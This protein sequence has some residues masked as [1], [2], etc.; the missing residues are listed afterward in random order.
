MPRTVNGLWDTFIGFEN[1][2]KGYLAAAKGKRYRNEVLAFKLNLEENL[3]AIIKDLQENTYKPLPLRQF[4]ITDPKK[5]LISAPAFRDRVVHHAL[6]RIIEPIFE[7]RFIN[8]SFA[9]RVGRGT[10][11]AMQHVHKSTQ[12][13]KRRWGNYYVFKGDVT[14]Y[15]P[16]INHDILKQDVR[17]AIRDRKILYLIDTIIDSHN[18]DGRERT[19][20][21]IGTLT[22]QLFANIYLDPLDHFLK[23]TCQ[24]KYY[25]RYM[26]DFLIIHGD[27]NFLRELYGWI[28]RLLTELKVSLNPKTEIYHGK[29][30]I[31]FCGYRIWPSHIKPRKRTVKRAKRRMRKMTM[32]YQ[33]DPAVL[34]HAKA[35]LQSFLGYIMHCSGYRTTKSLLFQTAFLPKKG[36]ALTKVKSRV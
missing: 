31:D 7:K 11:A 4:F 17:R 28:E 2:Y 33:K 21:P 26:D 8:E 5:R 1:I 3:F 34:E 22:S 18:T 25:A 13:A 6:V 19:G 12:L 14:K 36:N 15:F 23:E 27:K 16:S 24:I 35:S 20:I 9:C 29:Q 32:L 10:H 30:G